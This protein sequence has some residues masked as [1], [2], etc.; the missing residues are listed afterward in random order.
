MRIQKA[1]SREDKK[2]AK[3][4]VGDFAKIPLLDGQFD[5]GTANRWTD[6][7]FKVTDVKKKAQRYVYKIKD[8]TREPVTSI[9]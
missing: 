7:V 2:T 1:L 4:K 9:F 5:K 6:E 3:F 8:L